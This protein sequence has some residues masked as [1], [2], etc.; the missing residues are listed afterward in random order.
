MDVPLRAGA[1]LPLSLL[2]VKSMQPLPWAI[3]AASRCEINGVRRA[4]AQLILALLVCAALLCR[5]ASMTL[6]T[7]VCLI[8]LLS[9]CA[10]LPATLE[11]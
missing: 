9:D 11:P 10:S 1:G 5:P 2:S 6:C 7:K 8:S 4:A 3:F